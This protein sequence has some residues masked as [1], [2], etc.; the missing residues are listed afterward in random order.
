[1]SAATALSRQLTNWQETRDAD[2]P[3]AVRDI[4][5]R[6]GDKWS[7]LI[8]ITLAGGP[9]RFNALG[10]VIP[11]ISKR[12]LAQT[13]R[14]LERDGLIVRE[15]FPTKPPGVEYRLSPLG[16]SLLEPLA[17]LNAWADRHQAVIMANRH[18]YDLGS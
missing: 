7:T 12:M 1:M 13:L 10:R 6:I 15:V 8:I 17:A 11:D 14:A 3:C 16:Q 5:D 9:C 18:H 4:L 2:S